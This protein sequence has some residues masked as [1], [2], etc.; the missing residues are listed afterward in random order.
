[1]SAPAPETKDTAK[2]MTLG[3]V[4]KSL[5][6]GAKKTGSLVK[7]LFSKEPTSE[8]VV[9][10]KLTPAEYLG[11]IFKMMKIMDEDK[12]LNHEMANNHLEE[13]ERKKDIRN[14]E[15]IEALTGKKVK[16]KK[17]LRRK[18]KTTKKKTTKEVPTFGSASS[19]SSA[20]TVGKVITAVK[21]A[22][23]VT[24]GLAGV[25][26]AQAVSRKMEVNVNTKEDA[27]KNA[28]R[29]VTG[30]TND[31]TALGVYGISSWRGAGGKG[32]STLDSFI[33]DYNR[34]HPNNKIT[35]DPG[36]KADNPKFLAQWNNIPAKD[37]LEA[38]DKW[39][40]NRVYKPTAT[41][42]E[43]S[44]V[45]KDIFSSDK[46]LAY[47][48][49][50]TNQQGLGNITK[51][52]KAAGATNSKTPD[53]FIDAM[54]KYDLS[55]IE[56]KF[57]TNIKENGPG[58][59]RALE[60]RVKNRADQSK[61]IGE[62]I[63]PVE[64]KKPEPIKEESVKS[65]KPEPVSGS[66]N[67]FTPLSGNGDL[68]YDKLTDA[69]KNA[70][71]LMFRQNGGRFPMYN[72]DSGKM[73]NQQMVKIKKQGLTKR[74]VE[75]INEA[76]SK[77]V[78]TT[79]SLTNENG[80]D[81]G[82]EE[83]FPSWKLESVTE[84]LPWSVTKS[85]LLDLKSLDL[86]PELDMFSKPVEREKLSA[87]QQAH[88]DRLM[89]SI[90]KAQD[91]LAE[92]D[93]KYEESEY[94]EELLKKMSRFRLQA[95]EEEKAELARREGFE[96]DRAESAAAW[97]TQ[98]AQSDANWNDYNKIKEQQ[99]VYEEEYLLNW[100]AWMDRPLNPAVNPNANQNNTIPEGKR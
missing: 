43:D 69:Q 57:R 9:D 40:E 29:R 13:E 37:L 71:E 47:M 58:R 97:A 84:K 23:V 12:K 79:E 45:S 85:N 30:D 55:R 17:N 73:W 16:G 39:Y 31:S 91:D 99:L 76:G 1:M 88:L 94:T 21:V 95:A 83:V 53:E 70:V 22:A 35:E 66:N 100:Q 63:K 65:K 14:R 56:S 2:K 77:S 19:S 4:G 78:K 64:S 42:L 90:E 44:G 61:L 86:P 48:S 74:F 46:V 7:K 27:L 33:D 6:G 8:L 54:T 80:L 87:D 15:I 49:D 89:P 28:H 82:E 93:R 96:R 68:S 32:K 52:I 24:I 41:A 72:D 26:A 34:D 36:E 38:Q 5:L 60:N 11:E 67:N 50:R 62:K 3:G 59:V 25:S 92:A 10:E 98:K 75:L 18:P 51:A 20:G 81:S